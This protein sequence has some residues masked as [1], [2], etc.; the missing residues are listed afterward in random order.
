MSATSRRAIAPATKCGVRLLFAL[1][2]SHRVVGEVFPLSQPS[3][4]AFRVGIDPSAGFDEANVRAIRRAVAVDVGSSLPCVE[5]AMV[6]DSCGRIADRI[7]GVEML[8]AVEKA[9][10]KTAVLA[11]AQRVVSDAGDEAA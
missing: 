6:V 3:A 1:G 9:A 8:H 7:D 5:A 10:I 11:L 2:V 4:S